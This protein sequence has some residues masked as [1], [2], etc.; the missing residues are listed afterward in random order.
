MN[1]EKPE[2]LQKIEEFEEKLRALGIEL[3][4]V[5]EIAELIELLAELREDAYAYRQHQFYDDASALLS[6]LSG[7]GGDKRTKVSVFLRAFAEHIVG[8]TIGREWMGTVVDLVDHIPAMHAN[9]DER[10]DQ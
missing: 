1:K 6:A 2:A 9:D 7:R 4:R 8:W 5:D 10:K 3:E